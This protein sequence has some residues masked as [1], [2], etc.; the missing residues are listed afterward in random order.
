MTRMHSSKN[1]ERSAKTKGYEIQLRICHYKDITEFDRSPPDE[2]SRHMKENS[3]RSSPTSSVTQGSR[4]EQVT[5]TH[6]SSSRS[7]QC[8][9]RHANKGEVRNY[10]TSPASQT[11]AYSQYQTSSASDLPSARKWPDEGTIQSQARMETDLFGL[12]SEPFADPYSTAVPQATGAE[13]VIGSS[14]SQAPLQDD[15]PF[16][17]WSYD[18]DFVTRDAGDE[19]WQPSAHFDGKSNGWSLSGGTSSF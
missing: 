8:P 6:S 2:R 7:N 9:A 18:Y 13:Q 19:P 3:S 4:S 12:T 11:S 16:G 1:S 10:A 15:A 17:G 14:S 5:P